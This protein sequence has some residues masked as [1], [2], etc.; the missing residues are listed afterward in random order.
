MGPAMKNDAARVTKIATAAAICLILR[1]GRRVWLMATCWHTPWYCRPSSWPAGHPAHE[2]TDGPGRVPEPD[3]TIKDF[4]PGAGLRPPGEQF[5]VPTARGQQ[6]HAALRAAC[7]SI[8]GIEYSCIFIHAGHA[9][10][11]ID[12]EGGHHCGTALSRQSVFQ[13]CHQS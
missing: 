1:P 7:A 13:T 10:R 2:L 8:T 9:D 4:E 6:V 12:T 5:L 3:D 11:H